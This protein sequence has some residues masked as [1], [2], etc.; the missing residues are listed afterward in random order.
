MPWRQSILTCG[1]VAYRRPISRRF[2][3]A[4]NRTLFEGATLNLLINAA[5]AAGPTGQVEVRLTAEDNAALLAVADSGPGV[6]DDLVKDIFEPCFTTKPDG[7][8]IGLLA[9]TAFAAS[10]GADVSV[11]RSHLGGALFQLRIPIQSQPS[12]KGPE[13]DK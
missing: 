4:L 5:Q 11:G 7:T 13:C 8:G 12:N 6:P 2:T 1:S 9:V 10:C 3:L